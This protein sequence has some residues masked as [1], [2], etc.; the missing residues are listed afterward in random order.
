[1]SFLSNLAQIDL[2]KSDIKVPQ[3]DLTAGSVHTILQIVFGIGGGVALLII[4]IAGFN[5]VM[6]AG[7][8]QKA[9]KARSSIIYS[10]VGLVVCILA[11]SIVTFVLGRV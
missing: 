6:S 1:M 4:A 9:S 11:F 2:P 7:D 8:P 3:T 5:F 10:L